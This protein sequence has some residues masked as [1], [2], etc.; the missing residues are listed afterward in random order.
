MLAF[1]S[2]I[3]VAIG[4]K[5]QAGKSSDEGFVRFEIQKSE[6]KNGR[7]CD[8]ADSLMNECALLQISKLIPNTLDKRLAKAITDSLDQQIRIMIGSC[9]FPENDMV[10][11]SGMSSDSL[12]G[13]FFRQHAE[14][15][16]EFPDAGI[17]VWTIDITVDSVY[18]NSK[19]ISLAV[20]GYTFLGGAHPN[21]YTL[22]LNFDKNTGNTVKIKDLINDVPA[23][24]RLAEA[25]FRKNQELLENQDLE[26]AGY[27]FENNTFKL[28]N[29]YAIT[30]KGLLMLYN[31]YEAAAYVV[32]QINFTIPYESLSG[33]VDMDK[34]K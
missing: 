13:I 27:F 4:C 34:I 17:K 10:E 6:F 25:E 11:L 24:E 20:N 18:Q 22:Y 7:D 5:S 30:D 3:I 31:T 1:W 19:V 15:I 8:L 28:P 29:E 12:S 32:G 26:E 33:I 9:V 16:K 14:F 2:V 23:F 21:T